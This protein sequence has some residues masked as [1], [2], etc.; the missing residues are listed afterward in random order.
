MRT[1][2][3]PAVTA[4]QASVVPIALLVEM[5]LTVP[6]RLCTGGINLVVDA[7]TYT[8]VGVLG[9]IGAVQET[10]AEIRPLQFELSGVPA[11]LL[12]VALAEPVQGKA[13]RIKTVI[14]DPDTYQPIETR[15]RWQGVLDVM[16]VQDGPDRALI[17]VT[18]EH[19]AIDLLRPTTS[20]YSDAEQRRLY[21]G[22][23]SLQYVV[24]QAET[25]IVWPA[26]SY[27]RK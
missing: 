3:A 27:G 7:T 19:Y 22:D 25:R 14:F 23:P 15:L 18:A 13:V 2:S 6:L 17:T 1:L 16:A 8:G 20:V 10:P 11:E 5:D 4:L 9:Q 12:A 24:Q 21:P 26:A